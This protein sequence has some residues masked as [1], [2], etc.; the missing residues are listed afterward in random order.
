MQRGLQTLATQQLHDNIELVIG[1]TDVEHV[2]HVRV[3]NVR[4]DLGLAA[5]PGDDRGIARA[6]V[7]QQ[8]DGHVA[9]DEARFT[10]AV[11]GGHATMADDGD[12]LEATVEHAAKPGPVPFADRR[13]RRDFAG[14]GARPYRYP[15]RASSVASRV[16][17]KAGHTHR[18]GYTS[19]LP[20]RYRRTLSR[21]HVPLG[22]C[23]CKR[24]TCVD[25]VA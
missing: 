7:R 25:M 12:E 18:P 11:D 17:F 21:C 16:V 22:A 23:N 1:E 4:N 14:A 13:L 9:G 15:R 24:A 20:C 8:L 6:L 2:D 10:R 5:K 19:V 3:M